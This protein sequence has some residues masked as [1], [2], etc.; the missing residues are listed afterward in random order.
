MKSI[1]D[2][3]SSGIVE[4]S[5]SRFVFD[6]VARTGDGPETQM[7]VSCDFDALGDCGRNRYIVGSQRSEF[8]LQVDI[9]AG[10]PAG[11]GAIEIQSDAA[12]GGK[13]VEILQIRV[14]AGAP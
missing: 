7:S 8:L 10:T 11:A 14:S 9:P 2:R 4:I 1:R 6:I 5:H 12:N 13:A 3:H